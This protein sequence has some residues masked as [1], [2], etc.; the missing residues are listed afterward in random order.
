MVLL[1][2]FRCSVVAG[3]FLTLCCSVHAQSLWVGAQAGVS[4]VVTEAPTRPLRF[5]PRIHAIYEVNEQWSIEGGLMLGTVS[6]ASP[7]TSVQWEF[8][9]AIMASDIR[10]R[11]VPLTLNGWKPFGYTG[12]GVMTSSTKD[13]PSN[14]QLTDVLSGTTV[15]LPL[16]VGL[17][18]DIT[19]R[20]GAEFIV[21]NNFTFADDLNPLRDGKN[22]AF[23]TIMIGVSYRLTSSDTDGDGLSDDNEQ[24]FRTNPTLADTDVER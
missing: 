11:Y 2:V 7:G 10:A 1:F 18:K 17:R 23:W 8:S 9:S 20:F 6:S 19:A 14:V 22:D 4:S 3:F 15:F 21:G 5:L 12:L 13:I 24:L 16:G